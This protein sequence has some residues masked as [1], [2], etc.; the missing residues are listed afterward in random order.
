M[1]IHI[2]TSGW[3]YDHWTDV[4]Y[5]RDARLRDRL[6]YYTRSFATVELNSSFTA[7]QASRPVKAGGAGSQMRFGYR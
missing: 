7:G 5:P 3:S 2:G 1:T 4:L 6:R